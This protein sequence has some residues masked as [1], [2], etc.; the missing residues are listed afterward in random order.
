MPWVRLCTEQ[1]DGVLAEVPIGR[2]EEYFMRYKK[3]IETPINFKRCS[4]S[5]DFELTIPAEVEIGDS[6][7]DLK[8]VKI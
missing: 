8:G 7:Y 2:E 6:W 4:L 3:N 1:H 5:R